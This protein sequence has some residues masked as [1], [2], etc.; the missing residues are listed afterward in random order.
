MLDVAPAL[1]Y[2][3]PPRRR[4]G[5][6]PVEAGVPLRHLVPAAG[7]P[8]TEV[9]GLAV[10]GR[11][12]AADLRPAPG[13]VVAVLPVPRPQP[14]VAFRFVLDVHLGRLARRLRLLGLDVAYRNDA[15]DDALVAQALGEGRVLLTQDRGLLRRRALAP[16]EA[17]TQPDDP[18]GQPWQAGPARAAHVAGARVEDQVRDVLDRF[19]PPLAPFTRCVVC[20]ARLVPATAAEVAPLLQPGTRRTYTEFMR[21]P[22][23]GQVYWRGAHAARLVELVRDAGGAPGPRR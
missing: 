14:V 16:G 13:T 9:G 4:S 1:R 3:L 7:V 2:L 6:V 21:C 8:L 10:A 17:A 15:D 18:P 20:G 5:P 22:A 23:C 11:P 12:V 19:A